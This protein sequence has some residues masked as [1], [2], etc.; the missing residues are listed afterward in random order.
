MVVQEEQILDLG[1]EAV[2]IM[3]AEEGMVVLV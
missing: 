3:V 1:Q 2:R